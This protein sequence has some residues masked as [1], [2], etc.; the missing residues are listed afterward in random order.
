LYTTTSDVFPKAA[1]A[2]LTGIGGFAGGVG[3]WLFTAK[4]SGWVVTYRGYN[5][6]FLI[7][8]SLHVTAFLL[9]RTLLW[10]KQHAPEPVAVSGRLS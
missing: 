10:K 9:M 1:V 7:M 4:I 2:S 8:G 6:M 5:D 3:G